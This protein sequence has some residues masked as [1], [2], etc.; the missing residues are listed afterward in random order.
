MGIRPENFRILVIDDDPTILMLVEAILGP[1]G[2]QVESAYSGEIALQ[3]ADSAEPPFDLFL[4]DVVMPG[5]GGEELALAIKKS[6]PCANVLFMSAYIKPAT[7]RYEDY[8]GKVDFVVKPF[9]VKKLRAK[10]KK[11]LS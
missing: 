7:D 8:Y 6:H 1:V 11:I 4:T 2:Y 9:S 10:V 5:I 3:V